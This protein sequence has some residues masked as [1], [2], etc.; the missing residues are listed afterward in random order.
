M[1]MM[2]YFKSFILYSLVEYI[3]F[4]KDNLI[5]SWWC[6]SAGKGISCHPDVMVS[7]KPGTQ[8]VEGESRFIQGVLRLA[9]MHVCTLIQTS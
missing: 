3:L 9:H 1:K 7:I 4:L 6:G 8:V 2:N 5:A